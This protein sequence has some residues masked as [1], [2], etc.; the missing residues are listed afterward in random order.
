MYKFMLSCIKCSIVII[1]IYLQFESIFV[2]LSESLKDILVTG[3]TGVLV[4]LTKASRR[5][6]SQQAKV[7]NVIIKI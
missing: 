4:S 5:L 1:L 6:G 3:H 7:I 2:E